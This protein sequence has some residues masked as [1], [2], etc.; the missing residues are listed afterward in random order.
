MHKTHIYFM[1]GL[2]AGP[3]IFEHLELSPEKYELHYLVWKKPLALEETIANYAMRM[4]DEIKHKNPVLIGVSFGGIMVQ[5]ISKLI[6]TKKII[7][8]SSIKTSKELPVRYKMAK[9]TKAYKLFPTGLVSNFED[10]EKYFIGKSLKKRAE[11]YKKYISVSGKT[12]LNWS[13]S[14]VL[15]WVQEKPPK[16][17]L[18]I[19]GTNDHIFPIKHINNAIEI[20]GGTHAMI[21][22]KAKQISKII[23]ETLTC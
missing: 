9:F 6:E 3:E 5:E 21:L 16:N 17:I 19:H 11:I 10:Y 1:P 15:N 2:A 7:I 23:D 20:V 18:H 22:T 8:I 12:Y 4:T 13:I 14:N